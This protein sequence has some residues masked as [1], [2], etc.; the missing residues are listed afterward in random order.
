MVVVVV[1]RGGGGRGGEGNKNLERH[2][3]WVTS[4]SVQKAPLSNNIVKKSRGQI[5]IKRARC[6]RPVS[7][8]VFLFGQC[9]ARG[10]LTSARP[11]GLSIGASALGASTTVLT[12]DVLTSAPPRGL[13]TIVRPAGP[14]NSILTS[15]WHSGR[16]PAPSAFCARRGRARAS[17]HARTRTH[18]HTNPPTNTHTQKDTYL[19]V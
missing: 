19:G 6:Q 12:R 14:L 18:M 4:N 17:T 16:T 10:L 9:L 8:H 1:G 3:G 15:V 5:W 2:S 7:Q 11:R 13:L